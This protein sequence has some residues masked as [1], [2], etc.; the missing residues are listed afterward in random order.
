MEI[1]KNSR[2]SCVWCQ[3]QFDEAPGQIE[4]NSAPYSPQSQELQP[5]FHT[6][7][8]NLVH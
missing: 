3:A 6:G 1:T 5:Y 4:E 8:S 2:E 7:S